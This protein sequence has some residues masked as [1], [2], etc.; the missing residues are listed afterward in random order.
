V[1][2]SQR[3]AHRVIWIILAPTIAAVIIGALWNR[4]RP[5][6][7]PIVPSHPEATP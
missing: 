3:A 5:I 6:D 2:R 4:P 1:T 7:P